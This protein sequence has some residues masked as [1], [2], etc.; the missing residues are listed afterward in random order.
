VISKRDLFEALTLFNSLLSLQ[1]RL[2]L[3][4]TRSLA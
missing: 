3:W 1:K 4:G 2:F